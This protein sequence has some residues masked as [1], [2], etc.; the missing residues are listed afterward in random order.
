LLRSLSGDEARDRDASR[1]YL[2]PGLRPS[3]VAHLAQRASEATDL[4]FREILRRGE[5]VEPL[6][7]F[8]LAY[9]RVIAGFYFGGD[10]DDDVRLATTALLNALSAVVGSP[11]ALPAAFPTPANVRVHRDYVKLAALVR[12]LVERRVA[13]DRAEDFAG[14]VARSTVRAGHDVDRVCRLLIG[15]LLAAQRV[16][17]AAASWTLYELGKSALLARRARSHDDVLAATIVE[18]GRLY[19][20]TWLLERV[21]T[22]TVNLHEF[23]L[24]KGHRVLISP[25]VIHRDSRLFADPGTFRPLRWLDGT[26]DPERLLTFGRG[27]HRCP[28]RDAGTVILTGSIGRLL[29]DFDVETMTTNVRA[30]ASTTLVPEGLLVRFQPRSKSG[31]GGTRSQV[32]DPAREALPHSLA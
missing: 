32:L 1:R 24:A 25:Y 11:F 28:G 21:V 23:A 20:P 19:P 22:R 6:A 9:S 17:A 3:A 18:A 12:P 15:S 31:R 26:A 5:I 16:P 4:V 29:K 13:D 27:L 30:R 7:A 14:V 8:E 10:G 2:N